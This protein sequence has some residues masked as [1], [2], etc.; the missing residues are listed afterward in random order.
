MDFGNID[1]IIAI[2]LYQWQKTTMMNFDE[3]TTLIDSVSELMFGF[4]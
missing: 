1:K 3:S 4:Q 2:G